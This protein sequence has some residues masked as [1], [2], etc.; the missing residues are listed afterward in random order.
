MARVKRPGDKR[1]EAQNILTAAW[2][3]LWTSRA[4]SELRP[5]EYEQK[6]ANY[7]PKNML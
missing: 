2:R 3:V 6:L 5:V 4:K 7:T 1:T